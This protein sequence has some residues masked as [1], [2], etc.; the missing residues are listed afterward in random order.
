MEKLEELLK[1]GEVWFELEPNERRNFLRLAK[2]NGFKWINGKKITVKDECF[3]HIAVKDNKTLAN[4]PAVCWV[5]DKKYP[6]CRVVFKD[7]LKNS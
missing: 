5:K 1:K 7:F 3:F 4:I 2:V 6:A